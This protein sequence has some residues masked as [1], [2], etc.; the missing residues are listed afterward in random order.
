M[1]QKIEDLSNKLKYYN[2]RYYEDG[3]SEIT[4]EQFD[5]M[6]RELE[7]LEKE[8]PQ[9]IADDS[10]TKKVGGSTSKHFPVVKHRFPMLSLSNTYS[11]DE[12]LEFDTKTKRVVGNKISYLAQLKIDGVAL[13]LIY[14]KGV[15][16]SAITRG[17]GIEGSVIIDNAKTIE[18]IPHKLSNCSEEYIEIRGEVYMKNSVFNKINEGRKEKGLDMM[19]NPRNAAAGALNL[20][21]TSECAN[22][23]LSF[24][25]YQLLYHDGKGC[26]KDSDCM[27]LISKFGFET[28]GHDE[29]ITTE[30]ELKDFI[31]MWEWKRT[32]LDYETDGLVFK[33][34]E[35]ELRDE[36]GFTSKS[37]KWGVAY[38]HAAEE[39]ITTLEDIEFSVGRNGFI[40]PV[41]NLSPVR[42]AGTTVKRASLYNYEEIDRLNLQLGD[43]VVV[44]KSGEIIPK[45]L[46]VHKKNNDSRDIIKPDHCPECGTKLEYSDSMINT[47]CPNRTGCPPQVKGRIEHFCSL[48]AMNIDGLGEK[49]VSQLVDEGLI[50]DY[51]GLYDLKK[52]DLIK[53]D[54]M[55]ERSA[56]KLIAEIEKSKE[57][58]FPRVLYAMAIPLVGNTASR[59]LAEELKSMDAILNASEERI[60][61]MDGLGVTIAGS[62]K[63]HFKKD[64][65]LEVLNKLKQHGLKMEVEASDIKVKTGDAL[66]GLKFVVSGKF[67]EISRDDLKDLIKT[68]G[69]D[70]ASGISSKVKYVVAGSDM[71]PSKK[72]KA[73]KLGIPIISYSELTDMIH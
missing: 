23:K 56:S 40:T 2:K 36:L 9:F 59:K 62:I 25:P 31:E 58:P 69:G 1:K 44:V 54:R 67:S 14:E 33:V 27:S 3:V 53:L 64:Y 15:L 22:R 29:V 42:L 11:V 8:Y 66:T 30:K 72:E 24:F 35:M 63:S 38:K 6:L 20:H 4:D 13:S 32:T 19:A 55:G 21:D 49:I 71:G 50:T 16:K 5:G 39:A 26:S 51:S 70:V 61:D 46:R 17:N 68:N 43:Q 65:N 7:S 47:Y 57:I 34:N 45:V 52:E 48:K 41:A 28:T 37:P 12:M 60:M 10:P 73:D 18:N